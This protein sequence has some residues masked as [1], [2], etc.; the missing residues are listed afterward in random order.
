MT[1]FYDLSKAIWELQDM[2]PELEAR[3]N[4]AVKELIEA[5]PKNKAIAKGLEDLNPD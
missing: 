1:N 5:Q 3:N 4:P 2:Q